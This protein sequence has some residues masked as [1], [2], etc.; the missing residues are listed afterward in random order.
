MEQAS[1]ASGLAGFHFVDEAAPPAL[2][3]RLARAI[4]ERGLRVE[5]WANIRF[6]RQFTPELCRLLASSGCLAMSGGL[7]CAHDRLL[8]LMDKGITVEQAAAA[9]RALSD[10][11]IMVHVYLMYGYPSQTAQE[12]VDALELVRALFATDALHSAYWHRFA[13]TAHSLALRDA[14]KLHLRVR[15]VAADAF[16]KNEIGFTELGRVDPGIYREGLHKAVYNYMHGMGLELDV[17]SWFAFPMPAAHPRQL[18][19]SVA[20]EP[21]PT[22]TLPQQSHAKTFRHPRHPNPLR[23]RLSGYRRPHPP[24][25]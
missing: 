21:V 17:R 19:R 14:S 24:R 20:H 7:E 16:A 18:E 9:M 5:W 1:K 11:G 3:G 23:S 13:L 4:L 15:D 10:A 2:L 8:A 25:S 22:L 6:E 12:L